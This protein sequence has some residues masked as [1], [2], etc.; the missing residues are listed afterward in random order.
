MNHSADQADD[1]LRISMDAKAIVKVGPFTRGGKSRVQV[2]AADHDFQPEATV[3]PAGILLPRSDELF[4]YGITSKVTSDCLVDRIVQWW[5]TVRERFAHITTLVINLDNGPENHSRRTQFMQR[6]LEFVRQYHV[7]VRLAYYPPYHSKYNPIE[8]CWGI[9]E[10]HWN[11]ALLDSIEA[12]LAFTRTMTWNGVHPVVELVT[13]TYQTGVKLT[14]EAM[15]RVEAQLQR[16]PHNRLR[17]FR[18]AVFTLLRFGGG[19]A[20]ET[21]PV[22]SEKSVVPCR[23]KNDEMPMITACFARVIKWC[24]GHQET[25]FSLYFKALMGLV[26]LATS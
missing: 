15:D 5:E 14:K 3:T 2:D 21:S 19:P 6:L 26:K 16:L 11:G 23:S 8:R 4:V 25:H 24:T 7:R 13:T 9:L 12:V 1:V 17:V 10:N 22:P 18:R 20:R